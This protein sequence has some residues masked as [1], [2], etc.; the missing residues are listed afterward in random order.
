M[1]GTGRRGREHVDERLPEQPTAD[2][3]PA[4]PTDLGRR[5]WWAV[6]RRTWAQFREDN[7]TDWAAAL[8]YYG[9]LSLFPGLLVLISALRLAGPT[10]MQRVMD[11]LLELAPGAARQV[12]RAA[13]DNLLHGQAATAGVFA[14][15]GLA[16]ALWSASGYVG[17][18]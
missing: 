6:L 16:A 15:V 7:L 2:R 8:T 3:G 10:T 13:T 9:V 12:L 4:K 5:S 11:S 1:A 18:F 14:L 17:A